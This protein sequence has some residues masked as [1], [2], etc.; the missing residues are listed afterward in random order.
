MCNTVRFDFLKICKNYLYMLF[1]V[2]EEVILSL[3]M[4]AVNVQTILIESSGTEE[5][6][7]HL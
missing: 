6:T 5:N 7:W 3:I 2:A 1:F 4:Y